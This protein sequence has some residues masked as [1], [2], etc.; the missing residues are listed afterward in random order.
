M[1]LFVS[2]RRKSWGFTQRLAEKLERRLDAEI[3]IDTEGIDETHFANSIMRNLGQSDAVLLI[4]SEHTFAPEKIHHEKD[5]VRRE[6]REALRLKKPIICAFVDGQP[7]PGDLPLDIEDIRQMQGVNFYPEYFTAALIKLV[8][9]ITKATP[10]KRLKPQNRTRQVQRG[11]REM[12]QGLARLKS[13]K[14][15]VNDLLA[16]F[17]SYLTS[18][19]EL[20]ETHL[21][22]RPPGHPLEPQQPLPY[23]MKMLDDL[24]KSLG[25]TLDDT[26]EDSEDMP[27]LPLDPLI[28]PA[29]APS[30]NW[31]D[32]LRTPP[33]NS[34]PQDPLK[35]LDD[36]TRP[37]D[38]LP[39]NDPSD[40]LFPP[41]PS[42]LPP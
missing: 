30:P 39:P 29:N 22:S 12:E 32:I 6:I 23:S 2:Y 8:G 24:V 36:I 17:Q 35:W 26:D 42:D 18:M 31:L 13:S 20:L 1:K 40:W 10:I 25:P 19:E 37:P 5:W 4:V 3:F 38:D 21:S 14:G 28:R 7:I 15:N 27:A 33:A 16:E 41:R 9:F 34:P 11:L